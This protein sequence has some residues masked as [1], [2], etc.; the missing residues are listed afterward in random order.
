MPAATD[1]PPSLRELHFDDGLPGFPGNRRFTLTRW[2]DEDSPF[3]VLQDLDD[4]GLRF[5]V[6]PPELFF[7]TY[8][9]VLTD[10]DAA[11]LELRVPEDAIVLV[12]VTLGDRPADATAN[13][14]GPIVVNRHS[15]AAAQVVLTGQELPTRAS[16]VGS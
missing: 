13:L 6:V 3:S 8:A 7:P 4:G 2:G 5:V 1:A 12:V 9:P 10:D 16:L 14:L 11:R 15:L